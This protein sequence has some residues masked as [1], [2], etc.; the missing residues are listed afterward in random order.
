M[1]EGQT[2]DA[3]IINEG[4]RYLYAPLSFLPSCPYPNLKLWR[5][6]GTRNRPPSGFVS[7]ETTLFSLQVPYTIAKMLKTK[8]LSFTCPFYNAQSA[9]TFTRLEESIQGFPYLLE[10]QKFKVILNDGNNIKQCASF[11]KTILEITRSELM[12]IQGH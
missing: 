9:T 5:T 11:F 2:N 7:T 3:R 4:T 10:D 8:N 6:S 1:N 12:K